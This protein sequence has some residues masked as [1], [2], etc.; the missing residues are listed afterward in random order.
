MSLAQR[1]SAHLLHTCRY[2]YKWSLRSCFTIN[3]VYSL[4]KLKLIDGKRMWKRRQT[5]RQTDRQTAYTHTHT[6]THTKHR[7]INRIVNSF[8]A[9]RCKQIHIFFCYCHVRQYAFHISKLVSMRLGTT[10]VLKATDRGQHKWYWDLP[11]PSTLYFS[12][13]L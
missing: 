6:H 1:D 10:V 5:D 9:R 12:R 8:S 4:P 11:L 2:R 7:I 13:K 3:R